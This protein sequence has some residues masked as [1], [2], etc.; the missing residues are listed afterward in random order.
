MLLNGRPELQALALSKPLAADDDMPI[1]GNIDISLTN[2]NNNNSNNKNNNDDD[3]D[4]NGN[5][6]QVRLQKASWVRA[7]FVQ[8]D[9]GEFVCQLPPK[10]VIG[11]SQQHQTVVGN[12]LKTLKRHLKESKCHADDYAEF[13]GLLTKGKSHEAAATETIA[14]AVLR[15]RKQAGENPFR[16]TAKRVRFAITIQCPSLTLRRRRNT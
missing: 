3:N 4:D 14:N 1:D 13:Q 16:L 12:D 5:N 9:N 15:A 2:N 10:I 11:N 8:N 6:E 7:F